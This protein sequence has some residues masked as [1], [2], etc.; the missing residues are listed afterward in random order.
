LPGNSTS[1]LNEGRIN[2]QNMSVS[3]N[4]R[5][6]LNRRLRVLWD[7]SG[8]GLI[9]AKYL[10]LSGTDYF[11]EFIIFRARYKKFRKGSSSKFI[12]QF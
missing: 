1:L 7:Y 4:L 9:Y 11:S 6:N 5:K 3:N 10:G 8:F 12:R 2:I